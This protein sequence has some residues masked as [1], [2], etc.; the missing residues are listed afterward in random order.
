V[1]DPE[2]VQLHEALEPTTLPPL[3]VDPKH[4]EPELL[5]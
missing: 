5:Q 2:V 4:D 3:Q 1:Y